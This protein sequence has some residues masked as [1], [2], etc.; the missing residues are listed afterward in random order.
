MRLNEQRQALTKMLMM[1]LDEKD[2]RTQELKK[3]LV[4]IFIGSF[5]D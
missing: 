5:I 3:R 1:L 2:I 4:K